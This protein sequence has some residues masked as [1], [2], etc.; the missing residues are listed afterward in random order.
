[1]YLVIEIQTS[2]NIGNL[3]W[4]LPTLAEAESKY[5]SVLTAAAIS[6]LPCHAC[7]ILRNDGV[8]IAAQAYK[9]G[10]TPAE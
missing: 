4:A 2:D 10:D 1:M 3:V 8:Q 6:S 9:H 5:H 7:V